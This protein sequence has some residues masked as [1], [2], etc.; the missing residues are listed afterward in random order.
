MICSGCGFSDVGPLKACRR[1]GEY[2]C[3]KCL[4]YH[5]REKV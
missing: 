1:C 2:L 5:R 3:S 4:A